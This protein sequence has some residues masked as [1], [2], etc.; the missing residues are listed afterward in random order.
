[1]KRQLF[2]LSVF[3]SS[4]V[5]AQEIFP[6]TRDFFSGLYDNILAPLFS[7]L[8]GPELGPGSSELFF[9]K[10]L[11]FFVVLAVVWSVLERMPIFNKGSVAGLVSV[12]VSLLSVRFISAQWVEGILLPYN[13]MGI[14][15]VTVLPLVIYTYFIYHAI[16][17]QALQKVAW[18]IAAAIFIILLFIRQDELGDAV[19]IYGIGS[20]ICV[21]A[22]FANNWI[23]RELK[24]LKIESI[25]SQANEEIIRNLRRKLH[26]VHEDFGKGIITQA[27]YDSS[28]KRIMDK[29]SDLS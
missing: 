7:F 10:I 28:K 17:S 6:R 21:F 4:F 11:L 3:L 18:I 26:E 27:E 13:T 1:M 8:L 19:W 20:V 14:A 5:S 15:I 23:N 24:R 9:A 29:I 16:G 12:L 22:V 25:Y 2:L